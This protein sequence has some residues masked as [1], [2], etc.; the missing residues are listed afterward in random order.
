MP[1]PILVVDDDPALR[2][3]IS[4]VLGSENY[5]VETAAHGREALERLEDTTRESPSALVLDMMM[6]VMHGWEVLEVMR[7]QPALAAIP[8]IV[9]TTTAAPS[10]W[11]EGAPVRAVLTKPFAV[12]QLL[13]AVEACGCAKAE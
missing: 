3:G 5:R 6:P 7:A 2:N 8:V 13:A 9:V 1:A 11:V 10:Q 12:E 4:E